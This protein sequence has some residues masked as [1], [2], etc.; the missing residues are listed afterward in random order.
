[1]PIDPL[2][3]CTDARDQWQHQLACL[4]LA[5]CPEDQCQAVLQG[6][7]STAT[8]RVVRAH[9]L[10]VCKAQESGTSRVQKKS[11]NPFP[12]SGSGSE[13]HL[14]NSKPPAFPYRASGA[15]PR[16][17]APR[18]SQHFRHKTHPSILWQAREAP[19]PQLSRPHPRLATPSPPQS[20]GC[21][22]AWPPP[23]LSGARTIELQFPPPCLSLSSD[24]RVRIKETSAPGTWYSLPDPHQPSL[25]CHISS[26]CQPA[27]PFHL[28]HTLA[29]PQPQGMQNCL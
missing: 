21:L 25:P 1:M 6:Q 15:R 23:S 20:P 13:E 17:V 9:P 16:W 27:P 26:L 11:S 7:N 22:P 28:L 5:R 10:N 4:G 19:F 18:H 3:W 24:Q 14:N 29:Q 8:W 12:Q 2:P